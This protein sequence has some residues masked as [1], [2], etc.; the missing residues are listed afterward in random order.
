MYTNALVELLASI[1]NRVTPPYWGQQRSNDQLP[2]L[3]PGRGRKLVG[4]PLV[5]FFESRQDFLA[6]IKNYHSQGVIVE[7]DW[8]THHPLYPGKYRTFDIPKED[9]DLTK[10]LPQLVPQFDQLIDELLLPL[11]ALGINVLFR[12]F[13]EMT[14]GWFWWG[15]NRNKTVNTPESIVNAFRWLFSYLEERGCT[16]TAFIWN[17]NYHDFNAESLGISVYP[18]KDYCHILS[19]DCYHALENPQDVASK[20]QWISELAKREGKP[21]ALAEFG[22]SIKNDPWKYMVDNDPEAIP[23]YWRRQ[24]EFNSHFNFCF[25][26]TWFHDSRKNQGWLPI[27]GRHELEDLAADEFVRD[28]YSHIATRNLDG[29]QIPIPEPANDIHQLVSNARQLNNQLT[30][31]LSELES[32]LE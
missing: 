18:G 12:P 11:K 17:V 24:A 1:D 23:G 25:V 20:M 29:E 19:F 4:L 30:A 31:C 32:K 14:G 10:F 5:D 26:R 9:C 15:L 21:L 16:N 28:F 2:D 3:V 22:I 6:E 7:L 27:R 8:H 13:H